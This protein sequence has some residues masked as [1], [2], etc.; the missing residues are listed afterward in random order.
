MPTKVNAGVNMFE[1]RTFHTLTQYHLHSCCHLKQIIF[2]YILKPF[3]IKCRDKMIIVT[4]LKVCSSAS[5]CI[6]VNGL[7]EE[8]YAR[9]VALM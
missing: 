7:T 6:Q 8:H 1:P 5:F 3:K 9:P 4:K 2:A